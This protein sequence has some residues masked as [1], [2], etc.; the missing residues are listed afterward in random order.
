[1]TGGWADDLALARELAVLGGGEALERFRRIPPP[2]RK[3][4]GSW[5]TEADL[6]AEAAIRERLA[7]VRPDDDI[8]GEEGGHTASGGGPARP[9][10]RTWVIDPIDSTHSYM[11]GIP[12]WATLV[13]LQVDGR[14]VLGVC[15]VPA[16]GE[17]YT[18]AD[19]AGAQMNDEP[20]S[21]R[22]TPLAEAVVTSPGLRSMTRN[23][24][25]DLYRRLADGCWRDRSLGDF[26][27]HML[28]AR[29]AAQVMVDPIVAIWD[30]AALEPIVREA[31]GTMTQLD[32]SPLAHDGSCLTTCGA[33]MHA[34]VTEMAAGAGGA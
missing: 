13:G 21:V 9:G 19:G 2:T 29:G 32:G 20:I 7:R 5:V 17:T 23:G 26:W 6:A 12:L 1:V 24:R 15:H 16:L 30:Y 27:G 31:G 3:R 8:L 34:T 25:F 28:V 18:A 14:S 4:D 10:A 22:E 11:V 33:A